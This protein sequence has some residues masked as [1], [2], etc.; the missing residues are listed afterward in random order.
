MLLA[1]WPQ[2]LACAP[3]PTLPSL[4]LPCPAFLLPCP[5]HVFAMSCVRAGLAAARQLRMLGYRVVVVE[6]RGRPGG[7]VHTK[8]MEVRRPF[9]THP[10][11]FE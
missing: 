9:L 3:H 6:G 8:R 7:R 4:A 1:G 10:Y 11:K 2:Q 5:D